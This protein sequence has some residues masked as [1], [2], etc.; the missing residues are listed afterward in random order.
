[1]K[2][3]TL[4]RNEKALI[5]KASAGDRDAQRALYE[6]LAP[7][8]LATC[9]R[10]IRDRHFAEDVM[11]EGFVKVF[12]NLGQ[13]R[14]EGAFEAWVRRIMVRESIDYLRRRQ[15]VVFQEELPEP[16]TRP[17]PASDFLELEHIEACIDALPEGYRMVFILAAV[18][19]YSHPEIA[20]MLDIS[21]GTSKSQLYKARQV[22]Q[23]QL[24]TL[25][26]HRYGTR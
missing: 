17:T 11:V 7:R 16:Q 9:R 15:F 20:R 14:F 21:E 4:F 3:I 12:K 23:A 22:L 25:A 1:M 18:E 24:S 13:Y 19:G 26:K 5:R 6:Q 8:M 2:I 10:Y